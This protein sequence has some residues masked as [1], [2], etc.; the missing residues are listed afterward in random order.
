[1][2]GLRIDLDIDFFSLVLNWQFLG[3]V[4]DDLLDLVTHRFE[5]F[6][7]FERAVFDLGLQRFGDFAILRDKAGVS[8]MIVHGF[9]VVK[10]KQLLGFLAVLV[11]DVQVGER[12]RGK[13][14]E[15][16][17]GLF[18]LRL[19]SVREVLVGFVRNHGQCIGLGLEAALTFLI[20]AQA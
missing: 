19:E 13:C 12:F 7:Q 16:E 1:M 2:F 17:S 18:E 3:H 15:P 5:L 4:C 8:E 11:D 20:D 6:G 9:G 14:A 10:A